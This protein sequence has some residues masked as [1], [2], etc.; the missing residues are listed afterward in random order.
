MEFKLKYS[1]D[2]CWDAAHMM[3]NLFDHQKQF[4]SKTPTSETA[5]ILSIKKVDAYTRQIEWYNDPLRQMWTD[6]LI[7]LES[8]YPPTRII[9]M[10]RDEFDKSEFRSIKID[11]KTLIKRVK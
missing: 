8:I 11:S 2:Y 9:L 3:D 6:A 5:A 1:L 10:S 7:K 4:F